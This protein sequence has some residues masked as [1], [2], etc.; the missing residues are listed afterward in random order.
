MFNDELFSDENS[1]QIF[2]LLTETDWE[3]NIDV[4]TNIRQ[5]LLNL[6]HI[7]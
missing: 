1:E 5:T 2:N 4:L 7:E 3:Q 6:F